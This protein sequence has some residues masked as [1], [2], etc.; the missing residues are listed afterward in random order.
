MKRLLLIS[1]THGTIA[2]TREIIRR[3]GAV[4]AILHMGDVEGQ[5][6][7][8]RSMVDCPVYFVKGNCD[9]GR[10]PVDLVLD[11]EGHRIFMTHGHTHGVNWDHTGLSMDARAC[12]ADIALYGHTHVPVL[13]YEENLMIINPGSASRPR[14][15]GFMKSY[16]ILELK[17][18]MFPCYCSI[19]YLTDM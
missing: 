15:A 8:I 18:N 19:A 6:E 16:A 7:L 13:S 9:Y 10:D 3:V 12:G 4:D 11:M 5:Q 17:E 1:D 14:Q 2:Y